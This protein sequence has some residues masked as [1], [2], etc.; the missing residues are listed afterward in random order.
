MS[1][2]EDEYTKSSI[3][4]MSDSD[5]DIPYEYELK[6]QYPDK[7]KYSSDADSDADEGEYVEEYEDEDEIE[8]EGE[9]IDDTD[10]DET[11]FYKYA[12]D[13]TREYIGDIGD[14]DDVDNYVASNKRITK[15]RL[16]KY[17]RVRILGDRVKQLSLGAKPMVKNIRGL[18]AKEIAL[19]EL[20]YNTMPIIIF[21]RLPTNAVEKW[22]LHELEK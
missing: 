3:M 6:R 19:K 16:F 4:D 5:K 21:R 14:E 2:T 11:C 18:S 8:G 9:E 12:F 15:P 22:H 10:Y 17:E 13:D 1:D 20:E 7:I